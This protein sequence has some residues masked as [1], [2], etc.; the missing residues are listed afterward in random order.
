[1]PL[2]DGVTAV[3]RLLQDPVLVLG[4]HGR[5][6]HA[7]RPAIE[8]LALPSPL[9]DELDFRSMLVEP[10]AFDEFLRMALRVMDPVPGGFAVR[11]GERAV[12]HRCDAAR[13]V[14][15]SEPYVVL[16]VQ[17]RRSGDPFVLL[18]DKL[19][20][21][22]R[23]VRRRREI[24]DALRRSEAHLQERIIE[25]ERANRAKDEFLAT[26]SH[27]LR[28]P[29]QSILGWARLLATGELADDKVRRAIETIE[30]NAVV[31]S[32]L[33]EDLLDVSRIIAGKLRLDI[34][35]VEP[36]P[37]V[38]AA[39]ESVRPAIEAK[40]LR[41]QS[42]IEP[43]AGPLLA[44]PPRIQQ[45]VWNLLSNAVKFTPKGG[46]IHLVLRRVDSHVELEVSD[47]GCGIP[48]EF[49]GRIFQYFTQLDGSS[50]RGQGGLGLGLAICR[51]LVE[52][53]G[54]TIDALSEGDG[55]G[56]TFRVRLPRAIVRSTPGDPIRRHPAEIQGPRF[57]CPPELVGLT[58]LVVD[59]EPD[60][61]E[62]VAQVLVQCGAVV[63][64]AGSVA[65]ALRVVDDA[66]PTVVLS[67]IGMP[68]EDGFA[69]IQRLRA[70]PREQGG[71]T[72][73]AALTAYASSEDRRRAL[74]A[75]FQLHVP[76][77]VEPAE[78]VAVVASLA[79]IATGMQ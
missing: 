6:V 13:L 49:L 32:Q 11:E 62:L 76:K 65:E 30:R 47:S 35:A 55:R 60:A 58:V 36:G 28:T 7:N 40:Q 34:Q 51:H 46:R 17:R 1:M 22:T 70:L 14:G 67:D 4:G 29:L 3:L 8:Q 78:L 33:I 15:T 38:D 66:R 50:S 41:F 56:A 45:I 75:G 69:F 37:L 5:V 64:T 26:V 63:H 71:S 52:L 79:R 31:Q 42:I 19:A 54:G 39:I 23:E 12:A 73:V 68:H 2:P 20:D 43:Q 57:E 16:F 77:P 72:P 18:T 53:H 10:D 27:E 59:D 21:L 48:A 25:A 74:M 9:P 44:D 61:R 24:E